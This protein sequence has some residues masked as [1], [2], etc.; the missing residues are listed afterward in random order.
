[1]QFLYAG[2]ERNSKNKNFLE[3]NVERDFFA[4]K[5]ELLRMILF[6]SLT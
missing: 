6:K 1:M 2:L 3:F 5:I 4:K